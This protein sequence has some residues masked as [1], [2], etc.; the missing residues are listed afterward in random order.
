MDSII[1]IFSGALLAFGLVVCVY[2]TLPWSLPVAWLGW[3]IW[4]TS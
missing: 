4:K 2:V 1:S 3:R